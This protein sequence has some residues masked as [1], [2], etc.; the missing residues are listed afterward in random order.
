MEQQI[1]LLSMMILIWKLVNFPIPRYSYFERRDY[2]YCTRLVCAV[3][4]EFFNGICDED[5]GTGAMFTRNGKTY[6]ISV[7]SFTS[8]FEDVFKNRPIYFGDYSYFTR[9]SYFKNFLRKHIG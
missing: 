8:W 1:D 6:V 9:L 7:A 5:F 3:S 2:S 4:K